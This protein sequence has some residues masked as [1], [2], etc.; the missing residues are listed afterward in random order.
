MFNKSAILCTLNRDLSAALLREAFKTAKRGF[1]AKNRK[2]PTIRIMERRDITCWRQPEGQARRR[3]AIRSARPLKVHQVHQTSPNPQSRKRPHRSTHTPSTTTNPHK[4]KTAT[5]SPLNHQ[6]SLPRAKFAKFATASAW[7]ISWNK[8]TE[9]HLPS[10]NR[11]PSGP[12]APWCPSCP[13]SRPIRGS[14]FP[15]TVYSP[16]PSFRHE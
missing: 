16:P 13:L 9:T 4:R 10:R 14:A 3:L 12:Y 6:P 1:R 7:N 11:R 8:F 5:T 2:N 15:E